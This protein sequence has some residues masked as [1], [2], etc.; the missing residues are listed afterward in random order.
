MKLH[1]R[2]EG[3][4]EY[5]DEEKR[6][7]G[8]KSLYK[9]FF[10]TNPITSL[11]K[12]LIAA[13]RSEYYEPNSNEGSDHETGN[14]SSGDSVNGTRGSSDDSDTELTFVPA[15]ITF[16]VK[17]L[18]G[19]AIEVRIEKYDT[20]DASKDAVENKEGV[21]RLSRDVQKLLYRGRMMK[22]NQTLDEHGIG[23]KTVVHLLFGQ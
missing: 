23:D 2:P 21:S 16:Y 10:K 17:T 9:T 13:N 15:P 18:T 4:K 1:H 7:E 6:F 20:M 5:A 3:A 8:M 14:D 19:K 22:S 11:L 12:A